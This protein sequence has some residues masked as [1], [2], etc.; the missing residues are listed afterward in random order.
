MTVVI[1]NEL[2]EILLQEDFP[3]SPGTLSTSRT[4]IE[5]STERRLDFGAYN[6]Q[7]SKF[8]GIHLVI[9]E[10]EVYEDLFVATGD[11]IPHVSMLFMEKGDICTSVEGVGDNFRF[12]SLQ[13]NIV[14]SPH[15]EE[16]AELK[17]QPGIQI[18]GLNF[19]PERFL[20]LADNNV[21]VLGK[22]ADRVANKQSAILADKR[23]PLITPKM[24]T[25]LA[26]IRQCQY[27]GGLK[28]LFL[29]SKIMELLALQCDQVESDNGITVRGRK[30]PAREIEQLHHARQL[31]L[32]NM[33]NPPSLEQLSRMTGLN[34]FKLKS[35]FK[36]I[37]ETTVFGYLNDHRLNLA[38]EL[39]L[40]GGKSLA[41]IADEAGYSS[42]Q[43]FSNAFKKKFGV[44]PRNYD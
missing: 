42:P 18:M 12:S 33:H 8:D 3:F 40:S 15:R 4:I 23:N 30:I 24:K 6:I 29:Q 16:S 5:E 20:E 44:S 39:I 34:E 26:E 2:R 31:L 27:K 38:K 14:Y 1:R 19:I 28:K 43:H 13:H 32:D 25:V 10:A 41:I 37:F 7:E 35:G 9:C 22:L 21:Q 17:K 11:V 36:A